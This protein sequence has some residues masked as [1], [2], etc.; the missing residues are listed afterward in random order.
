M[1]LQESRNLWRGAST[2]LVFVCGLMLLG[3][4][5]SASPQVYTQANS[6][7]GQ[8]DKTQEGNSK[9]GDLACR[10][11]GHV[12]PSVNKASGVNRLNGVSAIS[13]GDVWAVG[14]TEN[15]A[16]VSQ[17]L[18]ERWNGAEWKIVSTPQ[19]ESDGGLLGIHVLSANDIWTVGFSGAGALTMHWNGVAWSVV[20]A[21]ANNPY[22]AV[23]YS[24]TAISAND[25]WAVGADVRTSGFVTLAMHWNGAQW[26]IVSTPAPE[27]PHG[28]SSF[29]TRLNSVSATGSNDAWAV[30]YYS[31]ILNEVYYSYGLILHWDGARWSHTASAGSNLSGV[32]AVSSNNVWAVNSSGFKPRI[33]RWNGQVWA[34]TPAPN[35]NG[36]YTGYVG[37]TAISAS[38]A[39]NIW[40]VGHYSQNASSGWRT[41]MMRWNGTAWSIVSTPPQAMGEGYL[42]DVAVVAPGNVHAVGQRFDLDLNQNL[43]LAHHWDGTQVRNVPAQDIREGL[44]YLS[45]IKAISPDN[46][47][48]VGRFAIPGSSSERSRTM[49][50]HWDGARWSTVPSPNSEYYPDNSSLNGVDGISASDVWAVGNAIGDYG[51]TLTMHWDGAQWN[52]VTGPPRVQ[53]NNN[54]NAVEAIATNDVWAVGGGVPNG[55]PEYSTPIIMRWDGTEWIMRSDISLYGVDYRLNAIEAVSAD[56]IWAVGTANAQTLIVHWNGSGWSRVPSPNVGSRNILHG[57]AV[58][59]A[60]DVWAVGYYGPAGTGQALILH[61]N[62]TEWSVVPGPSA[63]TDT[64]LLDVDALSSTDIWAVGNYLSAGVTRTLVA[65]WNG[66]EWS[67]VPS[68]NPGTGASYLFAL[69]ALSPDVVWAA[70]DYDIN[71]SHNTLVERFGSIAFTDVP[72]TQTF[73]PSVQCLACRGIESGYACGGPF[74]PCDSNSNPYFRPNTPITRDQIARMVA[75]SAGFNEPAGSQRFQDV[76]PTS[77]YYDYIN[78][79][80]ARG[81][82][83]GYPCGTT[84]AEPCV[85]PNN[86][87]YFRP[88]AN[89]TRGQ[90]AKIV[91]NGAGF[92]EPH[93]T[94]TYQDV[95]TSQTFYIW[96]ERLTY[97][98]VMGGYPCGG[99]YEPCS[100]D[101]KPY[102]RWGNNAT[103]GQTAKITSNTFFPNCSSSAGR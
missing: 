86:R 64:F 26:T 32:V 79:M 11:G 14:Q 65:H 53:G 28:A 23:L 9:A 16:G 103:R 63:G 35:P 78:R 6:V 95:P 94:Q 92:N 57:L 54:L 1:M 7:A 75:A 91:S 69:D 47:W 74:E 76:P 70:G 87:P 81:L 33:F 90:I 62:G 38:A 85:A 71:L 84:L 82:I 24:V 80:S 21:P 40:A 102:F 25:V 93:S 15:G 2:L 66:T 52:R 68:T 43:P 51:R 72:S 56:D 60:N 36:T 98:G 77:P 73:Y 42:N 97:R 10:L 96:I 22:N 29:A 8:P 46:I 101:L 100:A 41:L 27:V 4:A 61:W 58:V 83:G 34:E 48:A 19:F 37:L 20:P 17:P 5:A 55:Y 49:I 67:V 13:P 3:G 31:Y 59:S 44:N 12:I 89:A 39:N 99:A 88:S 50:E 30:G 45:D 18:V